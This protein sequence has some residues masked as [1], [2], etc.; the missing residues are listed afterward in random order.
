MKK[1]R[2]MWMRWL[3]VALLALA[4]PVQAEIAPWSENPRYW[5]QDG[6]P[7]LLV[8][9][10]DDDNLFQWTE[11]ELSAQL[12]RLKQAGGNVVRNTMSDRRDLGFEIY[13]YRQLPS[14]KYDLE[15]W[16]PEYWQR[17]ERFLNETA[18]RGIVVQIEL[19]DRFDFTDHSKIKYWQA[20][21]YNPKNNVNYSYWRSGFAPAYYDHPGQNRQPFFFTTPEQRNNRLILGYQ[22]RFIDKVLEYALQYDHVLYCIDNET[23]AEE[24]W[25]R[26]WAQYVKSKAALQGKTV[27]LTEMMG[28]KTMSKQAHGRTLDHPE[29]YDF[30]EVSQNNHS[31]GRTH[32]ENLRTFREHLDDK[33]RPLNSIK[34]YGADGNAFGHSD[35]QAL[36]RFWRNLLAGVAAA[37]FHRP[38]SGLGL[39][40]KAVTAIRAARLLESEVPFWTLVPLPLQ[41]SEEE[42]RFYEARSADG[43]RVLYFP[44]GKAGPGPSAERGT[45]RWLNLDRAAWEPEAKLTGAVTPPNS[46]NWIAVLRPQD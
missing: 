26:Y 45:L 31:N 5:A 36:E 12:D 41:G 32:W 3:L 20:H 14:G 21:P 27:Y 4:Q 34:I 16:N 33:P 42:P 37:R 44:A 30:I 25:S 10:S 1:E 28:D 23:S 35:Q 22:R 7:V 13:P 29:L 2:S 38:Q 46:G 19:W 6:K 39:S 8:G 24:A 43:A 9:G 40:D 17:F 18:R 15:Q 11:P